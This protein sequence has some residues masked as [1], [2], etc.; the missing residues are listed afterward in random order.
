MGPYLV[1]LRAA[2]QMMLQYR[3][4]AV[5]GVLTQIF[6]GLLRVMIFASLYNA[7]SHAAPMSFADVVTYIWI[8]QALFQLLPFGAEREIALMIRSG[9][10]VYELARP[11]DLSRNI[12]G[13][14][15]A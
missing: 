1:I 2:F 4:A 12:P 13:R 14:L 11:L 7:T 3:S 15:R 6:W 8:G 5:A 9:G 10:V